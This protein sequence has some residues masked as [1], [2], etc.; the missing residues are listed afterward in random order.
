MKY[1]LTERG[2][3]I[4]RSRHGLPIARDV[5]S[6]TARQRGRLLSTPA[7]GH[8]PKTDPHDDGPKPKPKVTFKK[9]KGNPSPMRVRSTRGE[10]PQKHREGLVGILRKAFGS[11]P[12][13][14]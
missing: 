1:Y 2:E 6:T 3:G 7:A 9:L 12:E 11:K 10:D 4:Y 14:N 5:E 8:P 13:G